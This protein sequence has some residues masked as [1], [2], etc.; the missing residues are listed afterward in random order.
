MA[1]EIEDRFKDD[2]LSPFIDIAG[3]RFYLANDK[4]I[5][6]LFGSRS[7]FCEKYGSDVETERL[8]RKYFP[9]GQEIYKKIDNLQ[10]RN[11]IISILEK[12]FTKI[13]ESIHIMQMNSSINIVNNMYIKKIKN[14]LYDVIDYLKN[15]ESRK[16]E[17]NKQQLN[18]DISIK[19]TQM[20]DEDRLM[21]ILQLSWY[22]MHPDE[23][24]S[25][26]RRQWVEIIDKL[27]NMNLEKITDRIRSEK[28]NTTKIQRLNSVNANDDTNPLQYISRINIKN[29]MEQSTLTDAMKKA[30]DY[31]LNNSEKKMQA[32]LKNRMQSILTVLEMKRYIDKNDAS[33]LMNG[34]SNSRNVD[35]IISTLDTDLRHRIHASMKP[36]YKFYDTLYEPIYRFLNTSVDK[37]IS[38]EQS[39]DMI[40]SDILDIL[41]KF[42]ELLGYS[43]INSEKTDT[44]VQ[45]YV[46]PEGVIKIESRGNDK[47]M[48]VLFNFFQS[49]LR[50]LDEMHEKN[51][52]E[53]KEILGAFK[54]FSEG[55]FKNTYKFTN[56][57]LST[58]QYLHLIEPEEMENE[59]SGIHRKT[60]ESLRSLQQKNVKATDVGPY[61][62]ISQIKHDFY[63]FFGESNEV[64]E[65]VF[66]ILSKNDMNGENSNMSL[67]TIDINKVGT[68]NETAK[69]QIIP[70]SESIFNKNP[71]TFFIKD[72]MNPNICIGPAVLSLLVVVLFD[73]IN[74]I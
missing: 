62:N 71:N 19:S 52:T 6:L 7:N 38:I 56:A 33:K 48:A 54:T 30:I 1:C 57:C 2:G 67:Y 49:I 44:T 66:Y 74:V 35:T 12:R 43:T 3:E 21:L 69:E 13:S 27:K 8:L 61:S 45:K 60:V 10:D 59:E 14:Q 65:P 11:Y 15:Y 17:T 23:I 51:N 16:N 39:A 68:M 64:G 42:I 29:V 36:F 4:P 50:D 37:Y 46:L 47:V 55:V 25:S 72:F 9:Y 26:V 41:L 18:E 31:S 22:L 73:K 40:R 34:T 58:R 20:S 63:S 24:D 53:A 5:D 70:N 28:K 32:T